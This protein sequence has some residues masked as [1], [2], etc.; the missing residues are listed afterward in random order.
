MPAYRI[1]AFFEKY[2]PGT[3]IVLLEAKTPEE[4]RV[5]LTDYQASIAAETPAELTAALRELRR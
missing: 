2:Y 1:V 3:K 4:L 5:L